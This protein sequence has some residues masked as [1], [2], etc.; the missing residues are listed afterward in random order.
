MTAYKFVPYARE[1]KPDN[2]TT[3]LLEKAQ[4]SEELTREEKDNIA[5]TLYG[6]FGSH[7][8]TY[9]LAGWAWYMGNCLPR[10]LVRFNY[11]T[12][13]RP[14]YAPDKTSLRKALHEPIRE[15]IYA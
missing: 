11:D 10:I 1:T 7:S 3:R 6:I 13:F 5:D 2:E 9:K 12:E 8:S 4:Q 15:M 14:Y